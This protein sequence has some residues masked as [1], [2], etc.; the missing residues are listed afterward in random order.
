MKWWLYTLNISLTIALYFWSLDIDREGLGGYLQSF[1]E[2]DEEMDVF[3]KFLC[4][5]QEKIG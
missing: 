3:L 4:L 5:K 2:W 1:A